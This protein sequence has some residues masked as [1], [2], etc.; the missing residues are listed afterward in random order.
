MG[1]IITTL[2]L[3]ESKDIFKST[4]AIVASNLTVASVILAATAKTPVS[5]ETMKEANRIF[6][7]CLS[8]LPQYKP[9]KK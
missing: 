4:K 7:E 9:T 5:K 3:I 2:D 8:L 6:A 1:T